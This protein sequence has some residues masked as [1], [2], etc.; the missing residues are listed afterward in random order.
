[1]R[2][3]L[4]IFAFAFALTAFATPAAAGPQVWPFAFDAGL[5]GDA[6][7]SIEEQLALGA[8]SLPPLP[9]SELTTLTTDN[10]AMTLW[11]WPENAAL[12]SGIGSSGPGTMTWPT[13]PVMCAK[14]AAFTM[15]TL[16][17][18]DA[19]ACATAAS[20][21]TQAI[22]PNVSACLLTE[23]P[24]LYVYGYS[25]SDVASDVDNIEDM[26]GLAGE[27]LTHAG[28]PLSGILPA[29]FVP[30][31]RTVLDKIR[32]PALDAA[33]QAATTGYAQASSLL[34]TNASC[35][36]PTT[37]ANLTTSL[38][39]LAAEVASATTY[40]DGLEA[41]GVAAN[42]QETTCLA[43]VSR[44]R[45]T[46]PYP[47]LTDSDRTF[48]AF[49]L[50]GVYWRMR[51]G[52][53]IPLGSTQEA[54]LYYVEDGFGEIAALVGGADGQNNTGAPF[55]LEL[56]TDG[57]SQWQAMGTN[58]DDKYADL[59]GMTERGQRQAQSAINGLQPL[60]YDT[61]ELMT[62][63]IQMGPGYYYAYYPLSSFRYA[64]T[65]PTPYSGFIDYPTAVGEF[66][67]G[68]ALGLG[69]AR[70]LLPGK[71]TGQPPTVTLCATQ[72]CGDDGCGGSCGMCE[73]GAVCNASG[74]CGAPPDDAGLESG[75]E[76]AGGAL[77]EDAT[78]PSSSDDSG[79]SFVSTID[80]SGSISP[81]PSDDGSTGAGETG[82]AVG[83]GCALAGT[84][85]LPGAALMALGALFFGLSLRRRRA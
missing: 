63:G 29:T 54:R 3:L 13:T 65:M 73:G 51:G 37:V 42:N 66:N 10:G 45:E 62:G 41:A 4:P 6:A 21:I 72:E 32:Y 52:G 61:A 28:L 2:A 33:L 55:F 9:V 12:L 68:T 5:D 36:D 46:L 71:P 27:A 47:G 26:I 67:I 30:T 24:E 16:S 59:I 48:V 31:L 44:V 22:V 56:V 80:D 35:F 70:T 8:V 53:L 1:V 69:L 58:G 76:E 17:T 74:M 25:P 14:N 85:G 39:G 82:S 20:Q 57:W 40:L 18:A 38:N 23:Q 19:G 75:G 15:P 49:W 34:T 81:A 11:F 50:G 79:S 83:C 77:G 78:S 84:G 64:A 60:G 43:A 7:A